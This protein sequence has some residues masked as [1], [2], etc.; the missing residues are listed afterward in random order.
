MELIRSIAA[1]HGGL[2]R[3]ITKKEFRMLALRTKPVPSGM[4]KVYC[5][6]LP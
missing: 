2:G 4:D 5:S 6:W 1:L 3:A